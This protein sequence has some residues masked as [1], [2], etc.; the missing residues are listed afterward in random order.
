MQGDYCRK[1]CARLGW[2]C[3]SNGWNNCVDKCVNGNPPSGPPKLVDPL[4]PRPVE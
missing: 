3:G 1:E 4:P 2:E